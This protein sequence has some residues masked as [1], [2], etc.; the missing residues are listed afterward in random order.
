MKEILLSLLEQ[1]NARVIHYQ[2]ERA[3]STSITFV[4][5]SAIIGIILLDGHI[6]TL[7]DKGLATLLISLGLI[8]FLLT[9][10]YH[11]RIYRHE[12]RYGFLLNELDGVMQSSLT[13]RAENHIKEKMKKTWEVKWK[14]K[15]YLWPL[16]LI[17]HTLIILVGITIFL[18]AA[19]FPI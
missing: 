6:N 15:I 13:D 5:A 2:E 12:L 11:E 16:W 3:N 1:E 4:F 19:V 17:S 14:I 8:G 7:F 10:K 9:L 18:I